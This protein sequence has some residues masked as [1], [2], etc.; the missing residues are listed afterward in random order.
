MQTRILERRQVIRTKIL[1]DVFSEAISNPTYRTEKI[2]RRLRRRFGERLSFWCSRNQIKGEVIYAS[3]LG[4]EEVLQAL[5]ESSSVLE[6]RASS[7]SS[8]SL[9][10]T[11]SVTLSA[12]LYHAAMKLRSSVLNLKNEMP[13]PPRAVHVTEENNKIPSDLYN[14]LAWILGGG[15]AA[16]DFYAEHSSRVETDAR[17]HRLVMSFAQDIVYA[18]HYGRVKTPK[19]IALSTAIRHLPGKTTVLSLVNKFGHCISRTAGRS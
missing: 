16:F 19:H 11:Y 14:F 13:W 6:S 17:I 10:V 18:T 1:R 12:E 5:L 2:K 7:V 9:A 3:D 4:T 8:A 15:E